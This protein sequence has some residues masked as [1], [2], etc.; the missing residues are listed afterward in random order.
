[1]A[2]LEPKQR[3]GRHF[4]CAS[5]AALSDTVF[6]SGMI[7]NQNGRRLQPCRTFVYIRQLL[8]F[9]LKKH[10]LREF[11]IILMSS[12]VDFY[13]MHVRSAMTAVP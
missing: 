6:D 9:T 1:M 3:G 7:P 8:M 4:C 5:M 11:R 13:N 12:D 2:E 10:S